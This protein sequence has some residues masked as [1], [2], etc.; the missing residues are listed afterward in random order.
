MINPI[1]Y[2]NQHSGNEYAYCLMVS[3]NYNFS[4]WNNYYYFILN[5]TDQYDINCLYQMI[6]LD[7]IEQYLS[8]EHS[9]ISIFFTFSK[10]NP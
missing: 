7:K 2:L 10:V 8:F 5:I 4:F 1:I 6:G 3:K 9:D